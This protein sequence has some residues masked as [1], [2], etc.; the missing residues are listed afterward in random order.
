M[1]NE[2]RQEKILRLK[3]FEKCNQTYMNSLSDIM[4]YVPS[5]DYNPSNS[6][7]DYHDKEKN[8]KSQMINK[9]FCL[10]NRLIFCLLIFI[11][12][13]ID[14]S[15]LHII[16]QDFYSSASTLL[17]RDYSGTI[18]DFMSDLNYTFNYEKTSIN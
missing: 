11:L 8:N 4:G 16:T 9:L 15:Y 7:L 10:K 2:N 12:F 14:K 3:E 5:K 1:D 18:I 6:I 13:F 17:Q